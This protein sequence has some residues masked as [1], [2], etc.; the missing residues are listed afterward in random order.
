M[1]ASKGEQPTGTDAKACAYLYTAGLTAP[2]DHDWSQIYLYVATQTY[3]RH[4]G[5]QVP[6]D[7]RVESLTDYQ[8]NEL[9]RLKS[10][11]FQQRIKGRQERPSRTKIGKGRYS[12][13]KRG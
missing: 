13:A 4:K 5:N 9:G 12:Y 11:L 7:I 8:M 1:K 10:W 6:D 2:M 3:S